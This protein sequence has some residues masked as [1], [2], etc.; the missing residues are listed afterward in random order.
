MIT[1]K[2]SWGAVDVFQFV[3][4]QGL[5]PSKVTELDIP[6]HVRKLCTKTFDESWLR[7]KNGKQFK[8]YTSKFPSIINLVPHIGKNVVYFHL[9]SLRRVILPTGLESIGVAAF[10]NTK[11]DQVN[12]PKTIKFIGWD[13]FRGSCITEADL[14]E[15]DQLK[16]LYNNVFRECTGLR[17]V[18]L[19]D[20]LTDIESKSF[21]DCKKL[22]SVSLPVSVETIGRAVFSGC[23]KLVIYIRLN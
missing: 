3:M 10:Q 5:E 8:E 12:F 13:A 18:I 17:N 15:C 23:D 21:K 19:P 6:K 16:W 22:T 14:S 9:D 1:Q 2:E 4:E 7:L 20:S 11:V